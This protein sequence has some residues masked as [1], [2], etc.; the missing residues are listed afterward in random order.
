MNWFKRKKRI[1][2]LSRETGFT[3]SMVSEL[4]RIINEKNIVIVLIDGYPQQQV[5]ETELG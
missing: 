4:Q 2:W 5:Y 3:E 1:I